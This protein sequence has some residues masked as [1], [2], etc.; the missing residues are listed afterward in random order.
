[1]EKLLE[2]G[3]LPIILT[4]L[5][6][7]FGAWIQKKTRSALCN[8]IIVAVFLILG[9]MALTGYENT[10]Y[11]AGAA[12]LTWLITPATIC[13]AIPMYEQM[14]ILKKSWTAILAG[15]AAGAI[16][17]LLIVLGFCALVGFD[18]SLTVS[19]LPKS[20]TSAIGVPL[21]ELS[22]GIGAITTPVIIVTGIVANI[23]SEPLFRLLRIENSVAKGV[24][25]GT[26]GHVVGTS[27]ANE[28][29]PLIG[30]VSTAV[31]S[32]ADLARGFTPE[33]LGLKTGM[34][35]SII[36]PILII[37][38]VALINRFKDQE[39]QKNNEN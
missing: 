26:S 34:L 7:Q 14:N 25:L 15:I 11:Q 5:A 12:K 17:S 1:M 23:L 2:I 28:L 30:A 6:F 21:S 22:G 35:F 32:R 38:G 10:D 20:V 29:S 36:F 18:Y 39:V 24:A 13:L 9:F 37:I 4:L 8:P 27:K 3:L 31:A 33:Q 19:L 16:S